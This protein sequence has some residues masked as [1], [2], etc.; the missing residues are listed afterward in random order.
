[1]RRCCVFLLLLVVATVLGLAQRGR[2][3]DTVLVLPFF[4]NSGDQNLDWISESLAESL[5]EALAA[6][7]VLVL[8]R[9]DRAEALRR[10]GVPANARWTLATVLKTGIT[11]DATRVIYGEFDVFAVP[12]ANGRFSVPP[13]R[14]TIALAAHQPP[15]SARRLHAKAFIVDLTNMRLANEH[16]RS[17]R[18]EDLAVVQRQL[19]WQL[20]HTLAPKR[21]PPEHQYVAQRPAVRLDALESYIRGLMARAPDQQHRFWTQAVRLDN[22]LSQAAFELGKLQFNRKAYQD[23]AKWLRQVPS[24]DPHYLEATFLLGVSLYYRGDFQNAASAF[25][26]VAEEVP[27]N[28]VINNLGAAQSRTGSPQ[29]VETFRR[30]L[31]GDES[32]PVYHFNLGYVLWREK[33]FAE[34]EAHLQKVVTEDPQDT[35]AAMLLERARQQQAKRPLDPSTDGL[36]RLKHNYE[37]TAWRQLKAV[38]GT[39]ATSPAG[40]E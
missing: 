37:E 4:N 33:R 19:S 28:E 24:S 26:L 1:M 21:T 39:A 23:A 34:A 31:E 8:G 3:A 16:E 5:Q 11:L 12:Q 27:L 18:L 38:L 10:L 14:S 15:E 13:S 25:Q 2:A 20:L 36:E 7:G 6:E 29:S 35:Q 30:A 17:G 40:K 9:G 32:D 22:R